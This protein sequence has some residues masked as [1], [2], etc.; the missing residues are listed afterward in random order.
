MNKLAPAGEG[1]WKLPKHAHIVAHDGSDGRKL[2][3]IYSCGS[4]QRAPAAQLRGTVDVTAA[5]E[6]VPQP[7]GRI[8]KLREPSRLVRQGK[9]RWAV[10]ASGRD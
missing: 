10:R 9:D 5:H 1:R 3:T 7:N 8:L 2:L 4:A 6:S